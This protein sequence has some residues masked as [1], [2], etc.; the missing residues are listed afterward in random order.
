[1]AM[2]LLVLACTR[3]LMTTNLPSFS[4]SSSSSLEEIRPMDMS[5]MSTGRRPSATAMLRLE[6]VLSE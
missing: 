6:K 1:M 2:E 3:W 5:N 4:T